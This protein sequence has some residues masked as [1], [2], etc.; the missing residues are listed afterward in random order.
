MTGLLREVFEDSN[1][2]LV[3]FSE[4]SANCPAEE[5][6]IQCLKHNGLF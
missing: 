3:Y 2:C 1:G 5:V 4:L 6:E